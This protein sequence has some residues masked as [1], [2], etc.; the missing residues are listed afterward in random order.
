MLSFSCLTSE[1][2]S[3][4]RAAI[5]STSA[6]VLVFGPILGVIL[7]LLTNYVAK[8]EGEVGDV[9]RG[10]GKT[11]LDVFN[12]LVKVNSKYELGAKLSSASESL[13][14]KLKEAD[15]ESQIVPKIEEVRIA[16]F[17]VPTWRAC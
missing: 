15:G 14:E 7:G 1:W 5:I 17:W 16:F 11:S 8:T 2:S 13:V 3:T 12:Y 9:A 4:R 10:L 6:G